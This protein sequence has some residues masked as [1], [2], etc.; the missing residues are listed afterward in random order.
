[1]YKQLVW[2]FEVLSHFGCPEHAHK[3]AV[4]NLEKQFFQ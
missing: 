2:H 4:A 1:M 3:V